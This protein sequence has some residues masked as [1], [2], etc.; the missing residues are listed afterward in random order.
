MN[1]REVRCRGDRAKTG[2]AKVGA[3]EVGSGRA[4]RRFMN[5]VQKEV[6]SV[7]TGEKRTQ[8][9]RVRWRRLIGWRKRRK[10][11]LNS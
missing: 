5:V 11:P 8:R 2:M 7:G 3:E 4:K 10:S 1:Q 6:K 9:T